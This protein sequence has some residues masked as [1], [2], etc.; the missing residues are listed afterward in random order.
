MTK[1]AFSR[2]IGA[3]GAGHSLPG[4]TEDSEERK[5]AIESLF[6]RIDREKRGEISQD[7]FT[8]AWIRLV[9]VDAELIKRQRVP[10][11]IPKFFP[12]SQT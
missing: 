9:D 3:L 12:I 6:D 8:R 1:T 7:E 10:C 11:N 5:A 2:V 4:K